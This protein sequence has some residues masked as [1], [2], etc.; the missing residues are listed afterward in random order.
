[1]IRMTLVGGT[2]TVARFEKVSDKIY[3]DLMTTIKDQWFG[4]QS[5]IV[6][7]KLSGQVL[8][9]RTGLL[10]SSINVGGPQ[11]TSRFTADNTQIVGKVGTAVVYAAI[12]E[13]GGTIERTSSKG[14]SFTQTFPERSFLRSGLQDKQA[15][16]RGAI[17]AAYDRNMRELK[18]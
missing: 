3:Q 4:L 9:R 18:A 17:Q 11:S 15:E 1:M 5:Y 10:A 8:K 2:E 6:T 13:Y 7:S 14:N 12:H 16:I